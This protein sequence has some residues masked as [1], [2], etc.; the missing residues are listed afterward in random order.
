MLLWPLGLAATT[1]SWV[2]PAIRRGEAGG[3][4]LN[5]ALRIRPRF[6]LTPQ[7][8]ISLSAGPLT[9]EH[10]AWRGKWRDETGLYYW[11]VRPYEAERRS[12]MSFDTFGHPATPDGYSAFSGNPAGYWDPDARYGKI[13]WDTTVGTGRDLATAVSDLDAMHNPSNPRF[14]EVTTR[15]ALQAGIDYE[16]GGEGWSGTKNAFNRYNPERPVFEAFSGIHIMEG[17]E[18]G[19]SLTGEERAVA[20]ANTISLA[21]SFVAGAPGT[22][23]AVASDLWTMSSMD[24][25]FVL[26][27]RGIDASGSQ[28]GTVYVNAPANATASQVQ[29]VQAYVNGA[30]QAIA[31]DALSPVGRVPTKGALRDAASAAANVERA[32]AAAAGTPYQGH[33]G[34]VPD[35]TWM[36]TQNPF[37]WFD[38]DPRVNLSIGGQVNRYPFGYMPL[39]F[40][41]GPP[42]TGL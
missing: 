23:R 39:E 33:V 8:A 5:L 29:Q 42:P 22:M 34:H 41:I 31:A 24:D 32:K 30:N 35:T 25:L 27:Q 13:A 20:W 21:A 11:G 17:P 19:Q 10:L 18:L 40:R 15:I 9:P 28:M 38:L 6:G 12:F 1:K 4:G 14:G 2:T 3:Q 26:S 7:T 16:N 36:G 37:L